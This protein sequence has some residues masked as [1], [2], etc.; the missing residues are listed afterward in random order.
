MTT[1][2]YRHQVLQIGTIGGNQLV[3]HPI[4]GSGQ[5]VTESGGNNTVTFI[6]QDA[7]TSFDQIVSSGGGSA[8]PGGTQV[9]YTTTEDGQVI[10][11]HYQTVGYTT[12][13]VDQTEVSTQGQEIQF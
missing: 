1:P 12:T 6:T 9:V 3:L 8:T 13:A 5:G 7:P 4:G 10:Q 11:S 2:K